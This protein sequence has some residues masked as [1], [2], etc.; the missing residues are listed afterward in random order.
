VPAGRSI[1]I[2]LT[3]P[4]RSLFRVVPL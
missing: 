3:G 1:D 2:A 4:D